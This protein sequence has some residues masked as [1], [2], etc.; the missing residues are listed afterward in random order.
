MKMNRITMLDITVVAF[1]LSL[2]GSATNLAQLPD[3]YQ[4]L[5][6]LPDR[7]QAPEKPPEGWCGEASIQMVA[8]YYGAFLPQPLINALPNP[9]HPDLYH[10]DLPVALAKIGLEFSSFQNTQTTTVQG[11]IEWVK[12]QL[13]WGYPTILG[14]KIHPT[15]HPDWFLDHFIV[16][17]GYT[18]EGLIYNTTW[19]YQEEQSYETLSSMEVEGI[20]FA[21]T[22]HRYFGLAIHGFRSPIGGLPLNVYPNQAYREDYFDIQIRGLDEGGRYVLLRFNDIDKAQQVNWLENAVQHSV[23]RAGADTYTIYGYIAPDDISIFM[24]LPVAEDWHA[25]IPEFGVIV[26]WA[27]DEAEGHIAHDS[28]SQNH[29]EL[30]G[31][32]VWQPT[33]GVVGGAL[34]LDGDDD[35]VGTEYVLDPSEGPFSV[36]AWIND[37]APGQTVVSQLWGVNWLRTDN[38]SGYLLTELREPSHTAQ[39]LISEVIVTDGDWHHVGLTWD[40][41]NRVLYVDNVKVAADTQSSLARSVEGLNIGCGPDMMPGTFWSGLIDDIRIYNRAVNP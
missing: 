27:L 11:Y 29:A 8:L 13:D 21:N 19:G 14:C 1:L 23:F 37:G 2:L 4:V 32:P 26:H 5:L 22:Y 40:G 33:E 30:F 7:N 38:L 28:V 39:S 15:T 31:D 9:I 41:T 35:F 34:Q 3:D 6:N 17:V 24:S 10:N 12:A 25:Q 36:F 16:A 20:S 18:H